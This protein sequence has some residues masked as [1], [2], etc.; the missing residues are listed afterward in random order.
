VKSV[1]GSRAVIDVN[2]EERKVR[3]GFLKLQPGDC[4]VV[5]GNRVVDKISADE[6]EKTVNALRG[7]G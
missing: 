7:L 5:H 2:G 1:D 3:L 6:Y 4:V